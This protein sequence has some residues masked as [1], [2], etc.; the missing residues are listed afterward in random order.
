M[1]CDTIIT[2]KVLEMIL[3]GLG[4]CD[5]EKYCL[6]IRKKETTQMLRTVE[7]SLSN[8]EK[9]LIRLIGSR[10]VGKS[11]LLQHTADYISEKYDL[12]WIPLSTHRLGGYSQ[13]HAQILHFLFSRDFPYVFKRFLEIAQRFQDNAPQTGIRELM[14]ELLLEEKHEYVSDEIYRAVNRLLMY[15][16]ES[17]TNPFLLHNAVKTIQPFLD[18]LLINLYSFVN[19]PKGVLITLDDIEHYWRAWGP[20]QRIRF[21]ECIENLANIMKPP[22]IVCITADNKMIQ[23]VDYWG[24]RVTDIF[25]TVEDVYLTHISMSDVWTILEQYFKGVDKELKELIFSRIHELKVVSIRTILQL[26]HAMSF[27]VGWQKTQAAALEVAQRIL[28]ERDKLLHRKLVDEMKNAAAK[29]F[30]VELSDKEIIL[31]VKWPKDK[32]NLERILKSLPPDLDSAIECEIVNW[33]K[34]KGLFAAFE[35]VKSAETCPWCKCRIKPPLAFNFL[36]HLRWCPIASTLT[37]IM[38]YHQYEIDSLLKRLK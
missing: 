24:K 25:A 29:K 35:K 8:R 12:L 21:W 19:K 3:P 16:A 22:S 27:S 15:I 38:G 2:I 11:C 17:E 33:F 26:L 23:D 5:K 36:T 18:A 28:T 37:H 20:L 7:K 30:G 14:Y 6:E 1:E 32:E 9:C 34:Q 4:P 31:S 10:T 13:I